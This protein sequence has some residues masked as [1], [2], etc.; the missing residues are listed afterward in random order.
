M[1]DAGYGASRSSLRVSVRASSRCSTCVKL[2]L[3]RHF[4]V[5]AGVEVSGEDVLSPIDLSQFPDDS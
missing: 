2:D 5:D 3:Y 4:V 1:L